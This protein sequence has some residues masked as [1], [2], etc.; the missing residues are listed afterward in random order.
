MGIPLNAADLFVLFNNA[1]I[2]MGAPGYGPNA[3]LSS[4]ST[5]T[6]KAWS[7]F[8]ITL[9][10]Y[11]TIGA[12]VTQTLLPPKPTVRA[13]ED[14]I[15]QTFDDMDQKTRQMIY[16]YLNRAHNCRM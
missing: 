8:K 1:C 6:I 12:G 7:E 13:E 2:K 5:L 16:E 14:S 11:V 9:D 10:R 4:Q 3:M 15:R